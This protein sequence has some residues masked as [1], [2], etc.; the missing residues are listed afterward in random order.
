MANSKFKGNTWSAWSET[1]P[2]H[3]AF[4][5]A[6]LQSP[7]HIIATGR[8]KTETVQGE[9]KK[10]VKLGM[11]TEQRDGFEYEMSV[12]LDIVHAG[13]YAMASKD[14]TGLF[15]DRDPQPISE[16]TGR[17]LGSWLNSG[18]PADE[19]WPDPLDELRSAALEGTVSLRSMFKRLAI[20]KDGALWLEHGAS[21]QA[22]AKA[23]D[24]PASD[25]AHGSPKAAAWVAGTPAGH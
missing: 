19:H 3:R 15:T 2:R 5:E 4:I 16:N 11:K 8:S 23:A 6:M 20:D 1:T 21:L 17:A 25:P 24:A 22:A 12:V 10:V 9:G 18:E 13:H 7:M 14:R